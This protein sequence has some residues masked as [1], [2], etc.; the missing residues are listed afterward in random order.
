MNG[1]PSSPGLK[2]RLEQNPSEE[3][4]I[5]VR[6]S[7]DLKIILASFHEKLKSSDIPGKVRECCIVQVTDDDQ[8]RLL[9]RII[10]QDSVLCSNSI[11]YPVR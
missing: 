1:C 7:C 8:R 3:L 4:I 10:Y 11:N 6:P 9:L 2:A 5:K